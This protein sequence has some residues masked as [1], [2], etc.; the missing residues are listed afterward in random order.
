MTGYPLEKIYEEVAFIAYHFHWNHEN[1]LNMEHSER[2][3]W[4]DEISKINQK[5]NQT[6]QNLE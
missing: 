2:R 4:C 3:K 1:I 6:S 5:L